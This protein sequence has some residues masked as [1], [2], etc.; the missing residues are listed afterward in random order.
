MKWLFLLKQETFLGKDCRFYDFLPYRY[1]P[2]SFE[3]QRDVDKLVE[4]GL[5]GGNTL[6][7]RANAGLTASLIDQ[8]LPASTKSAVMDILARYGAL[9][10]TELLA[11][12]YS[13]YPWYASQS[14]RGRSR[15]MQVL[16]SPAIYTIGYEGR[17]IDRFLNDVLRSGIVRLIDVRSNPFSYKYGFSKNLLRVLAGRVGLDYVH[18]P[19]LGIPSD[20]RQGIKAPGDR[21]RLFDHYQ[22]KILSQVTGCLDRVA[23]LLRSAPAALLCFEAD[24]QDCHRG[25]LAIQLAAITGLPIRH[26]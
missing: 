22:D 2:F 18:I 15:R 10:T 24:P 19:E 11:S 17:S 23:R 12:V 13:R 6:Q 20:L 14:L 7:V 4:A 25:R 9:R 26:L 8:D 5:I 16:S 3:A 21:Q 1:G